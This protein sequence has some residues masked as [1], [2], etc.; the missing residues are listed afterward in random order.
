MEWKIKE[1]LV[2]DSLSWYLWQDI[3]KAYQNLGNKYNN[4]LLML[5][6]YYHKPINF[7]WTLKDYLHWYSKRRVNFKKREISI[8]FYLIGSRIQM[9]RVYSNS[10]H[11]QRKN[12]LNPLLSVVFRSKVWKRYES[13]RSEYKRLKDLNHNCF[14]ILRLFMLRLIMVWVS[15]IQLLRSFS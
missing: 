1:Y 5:S 10:S 15:Y 13:L 6:K 11:R 12:M 14:L 8:K 9:T 3:K 4:S 2:F 7:V